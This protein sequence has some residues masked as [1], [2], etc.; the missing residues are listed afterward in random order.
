MATTNLTSMIRDITYF[1]I[2]HFYDKT[3]TET[4]QTKLENNMLSEL[5]DNLYINKSLD[6]KKY[7]RDTL[8]ENLENNYNSFAVENIILEMFNDPTYSK[9]RIYLEIV[10]YQK[11]L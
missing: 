9:Q 11:K 5:I 7:I 4:K 8:N 3:L 6:L 1:Y 2:K 10:E